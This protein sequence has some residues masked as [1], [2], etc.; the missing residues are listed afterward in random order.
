MHLS[1]SFVRF[2]PRHKPTRC[3]LLRQNCLHIAYQIQPFQFSELYYF[4]ASIFDMHCLKEFSV[5]VEN[6]F[7]A[8]S[9]WIKLKLLSTEIFFIKTFYHY[10]QAASNFPACTN[11]QT[12]NTDKK[13]HNI[14]K[15][16]GKYDSSCCSSLAVAALCSLQCT[17]RG[18]ATFRVSRKLKLQCKRQIHVLEQYFPKVFLKIKWVKP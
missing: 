5:T 8:F 17:D 12:K 15:A 14:K 16:F 3:A 1:D 18:K 9:L 6:G 10:I 11:I 2:T 7:L 13:K 4:S